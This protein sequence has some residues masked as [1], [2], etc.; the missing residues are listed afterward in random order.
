MKYSPAVA[1]T[2]F[3]GGTLANAN[4]N[5]SPSSMTFGFAPAREDFFAMSRDRDP[6]SVCGHILVVDDDAGVRFV[7]ER[8]LRAA[9]YR[10]SAVDDGEAGWS[11]MCADS[12]DL[13]I[14]DHDMPR[15]LG[16]DLVRRL[17]AV[18][19]DLPVILI[20]GRMPCDETDLLDVLKPGM[21]VEKPFSFNALLADVHGLLSGAKADELAFAQPAL[22]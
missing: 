21:A 2:V 20:S 10:V 1:R 6:S 16:L 22:R 9:G 13:I 5:D 7:L 4:T 11:A 12:F 18:G 14:T 17:R 19:F 15:L 8:V 3:E